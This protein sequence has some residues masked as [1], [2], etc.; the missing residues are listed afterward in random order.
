MDINSKISWMNNT[1]YTRRQ[2]IR[3]KIKLQD[4]ERLEQYF[5]FVDRNHWK[6]FLKRI[7]SEMHYR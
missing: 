6:I 1:V 7:I 3:A 5:L 4:K 2:K